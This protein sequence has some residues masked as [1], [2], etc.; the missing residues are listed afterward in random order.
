METKVYHGDLIPD[1]VGRKLVASFNRGNFRAQKIGSGDRV[2]IQIATA[3]F[4]RSG[5]QTATTV[6]IQKVKDGVSVQVG[7]QN[8]VGVAASM[9]K[10]ALS[11]LH[12][13][14]SILGRLDDL[15]QDLESLQLRDRVWEAIAEYSN[16]IGVSHQLSE[17]LRRMNCAYCDT[18]NP[19]GSAHCIACGAPMGITQPTTCLNCGFVILRSETV[20]PNCTKPILSQLR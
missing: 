11:A 14:F 19:V 10:T 1:D 8:W 6:T 16:S 2:V 15:A 20:C 18:A 9:G 3:A 12:N 13:P 5:G 7:K 4:A 17:R